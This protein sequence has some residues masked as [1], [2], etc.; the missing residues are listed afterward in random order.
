MIS[1]VLRSPARGE[2][3]AGVSQE[4]SRTPSGIAAGDSSSQGSPP[5]GTMKTTGSISGLSP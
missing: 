1:T 4:S 5:G 3:G 2:A